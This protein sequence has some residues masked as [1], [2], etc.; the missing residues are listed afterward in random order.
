MGRCT[1][2]VSRP[3]VHPPDR[4]VGAG[5]RRPPGP[6]LAGAGLADHPHPNPGHVPRRRRGA[7]RRTGQPGRRL[8][9]SGGGVRGPRIQP[10][11]ARP[12]PSSEKPSNTA[13]CRNRRI[14]PE[15]PERGGQNRGA[16][17]HCAGPFPT[18]PQP[19]G[20]YACGRRAWRS[21]WRGMAGPTP[22]VLERNGRTVG[23]TPPVPFFAFVS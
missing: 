13:C 5:P 18:Q 19:C 14:P 16:P 20:G 8:P 7:P 6:L 2:C 1:R 3:P 17:G 11:V 21:G 22:N 9:R 4:R 12:P 10:M 15:P 23:P